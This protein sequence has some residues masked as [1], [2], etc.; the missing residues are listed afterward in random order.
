MNCTACYD[1]VDIYYF[2]KFHADLTIIILS[3]ALGPLAV[4]SRTTGTVDV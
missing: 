3:L 1:T 4:W 2:T